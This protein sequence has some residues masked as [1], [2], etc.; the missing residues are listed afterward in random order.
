MDKVIHFIAAIILTVILSLFMHYSL[1]FLV[2]MIVGVLKELYDLHI[3]GTY[4]DWA[5]IWADAW[6]CML[7]VLIANVC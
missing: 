6:G 1:A 4:F 3:K 5:D 7:G 2:A